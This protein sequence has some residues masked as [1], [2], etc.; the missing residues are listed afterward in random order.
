MPL[1]KVL[2][3]DVPLFP[4]AERLE[5]LSRPRLPLHTGHAVE[6]GGKHQVAP[7][8]ELGID[9]GLFRDQAHLPLDRVRVVGQVVAA[10]EDPSSR[11]LQERG[12]HA[13]AWSSC[14]RHW[15]RKIKHLVLVD[16]KAHVGPTASTPVPERP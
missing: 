8:G 14:P 4:Q 11:R 12:Q 9:G 13:P 2:H 6:P 3:L 5:Q 10:D 16:L 7:G 15:A 1:G